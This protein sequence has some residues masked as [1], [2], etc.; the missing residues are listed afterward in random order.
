VYSNHV[1][2]KKQ[3]ILGTFNKPVPKSNQHFNVMVCPL[4]MAIVSADSILTSGSSGK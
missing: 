4:E 3:N 2:V 1:L